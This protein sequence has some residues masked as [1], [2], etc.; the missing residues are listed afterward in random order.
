MRRNRHDAARAIGALLLAAALTLVGVTT[1]EAAKTRTVAVTVRTSGGTAIPAVKVH[2]RATDGSWDV[3]LRTG[4]DGVA[5]FSDVP[6]KKVKASAAVS[7]A[8]D[9]VSTTST[10]FDVASKA[11]AT[12]KFTD[13]QGVTG[14]ITDA[15]T[16]TG[17][18]G[19]YVAL[20]STDD[21]VYG[22]W[23]T[24]RA[25]GR[26]LVLVVA[27]KYQVVA[28][29]TDSA[30][31]DTFWGQTFSF[32]RSPWLTVSR[33]HDRTGVDIAVP[34][35]GTITGKV[36]LA[37]APV[38]GATVQIFG[39]HFPLE[40][41]TDA[42]GAF[43]APVSPTSLQ[44][45][46]DARR[47][48]GPSADTLVTYNGDVVRPS[49]VRTVRV[50]SRG[51]SA[52]TVNLVPAA[53]VTGLVVDSGGRPVERASVTATNTTR[54][55]RD[56]VYTD[57]AGRYRLTGLA[58]GPV[59]LSVDK[60]GATASRTVTL[61]QGTTVAAATLTLP[62]SPGVG[63][64]RITAKG[65][66]CVY[67]VPA[68]NRKGCQRVSSAGKVTVGSVPPGTYR[69]SFGTT[70]SYRTVKVSAGKTTS[71]VAPKRGRS[72]TLSGTVVGPTGKPVARQQVSIRNRFGVEVAVLTTDSHGRFRSSSIV[73]S[74]QYAVRTQSFDSS[75]TNVL[76]AGRHITV[77]AG[78]PIRVA[79]IHKTRGAVLTGTVVDSAGKPVRDAYV[80]VGAGYGD[81]PTTDSKGRF[82]IRGVTSGKH[83]VHVRDPWT[84]GFHN[85]DALVTAVVGSTRTVPR[86]VLK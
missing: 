65:Y 43:S 38:R 12:L 4:T 2:L 74:G 62:R 81:V 15:E 51:T 35:V 83:W 60:A 40:V 80:Y 52:T 30:Y 7:G 82:T 3:I 73:V 28:S 1:A 16:G 26:Y 9:K 25:D 42:S 39:G 63:T 55:G 23:S 72:T 31:A 47:T 22:G 86:F 58:T 77:R 76:D 37:G 29:P 48:A 61:T 44:V 10:S 49:Q 64:V 57:S 36:L 68:V 67:F 56:S 66:G 33:G 59:R 75:T 54:A 78:T 53:V 79:T 19:A 41:S 69:V 45:D 27:Q 11:T 70:N 84:G 6:A 13:V 5:R 8:P 14:R 71:L 24:S 21:E 50:T 32:E 17:V 46:V 85:A 20:E 18:S 34:H